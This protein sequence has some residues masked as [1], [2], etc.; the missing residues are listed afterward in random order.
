MDHN[1]YQQFYE[2]YQKGIVA[3]TLAE[4]EKD[5]NQAL[6]FLTE[7]PQGG[8]EYDYNIGNS[9]YLLEEYPWAL[10]YYL[11]AQKELPRDQEIKN[12][13]KKTAEQL[14]IPF[15]SYPTPKF[16]SHSE[17]MWIAQ[18]LIGITFLLFLLF[19]WLGR[20]KKTATV[21]FGLTS[22]YI[23]FIVFQFYL[24]PDRAVLVQ[25]AFLIKDPKNLN[26]RVFLDPLP[27]GTL[28]EMIG[29]SDEGEWI[30]VV[31]PS[32]IVGYVSSEKLLPL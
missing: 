24:T 17:E 12:N 9:Y 20:F 8:G 15:E 18:G 31:Q 22:F 21:L 5:I 32:G 25:A 6:A 23:L 1:P 2:A 3:P 27:P 7:S 29:K 16:F 26:E 28:L 13:I 19:I 11:R 30:K 14:Q 4:R 10:Y